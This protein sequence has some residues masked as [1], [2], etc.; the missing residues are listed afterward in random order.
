MV[1]FAL[2]DV[3]F[4]VYIYLYKFIYIYIYIDIDICIYI[5]INTYIYIYIYGKLSKYREYQKVL[6]ALSKLDVNINPAN[7]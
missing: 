6:T 4:D 7:G 5:Y 3:Y 2:F 1:L